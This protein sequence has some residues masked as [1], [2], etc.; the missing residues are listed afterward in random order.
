MIDDFAVCLKKTNNNSKIWLIGWNFGTILTRNI[1]RCSKV[2]RNHHKR[3]FGNIIEL[4]LYMPH[5]EGRCG[6]EATA[7][8]KNIFFSCRCCMAKLFFYGKQLDVRVLYCWYSKS[9]CLKILR[10]FAAYIK[11]PKSVYL[12]CID[13]PLCAVHRARLIYRKTGENF[14]WKSKDSLIN[15]WRRKKIEEKNRKI[16]RERNIEEEDRKI[17][18]EKKIEEVDRKIDRKRKIEEEDRKIDID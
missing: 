11:H 4:Y 8:R 13:T 3:F 17:D 6:V 9:I 16:D 15:R 14:A 2:D 1:R 18:R 12:Q 7:V 10:L 5:I